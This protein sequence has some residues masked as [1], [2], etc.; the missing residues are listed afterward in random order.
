M[1]RGGRS[2]GGRGI[3]LHVGEQGRKVDQRRALVRLGCDLLEQIDTADQLLRGPQPERREVSPQV[4]G[5]RDEVP[6]HTVA[7]IDETLLFRGGRIRLG[8]RQRGAHGSRLRLHQSAGDL[9][10]PGGDPRRAVS[11]A[12]AMAVDALLGDHERGGVTTAE[13]RAIESIRGR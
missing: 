1:P 8:D 13:R 2:S 6:L 11:V 10:V 9:V 5:Q 7:R 12:A 3:G 4:F